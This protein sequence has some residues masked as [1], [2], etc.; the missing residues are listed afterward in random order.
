[1]KKRRIFLAINLPDQIK[2]KLLEFQREWADLPVRWTK[3][4]NLHI[5][6]V[7][8]GYIDD[9]EMLEICRLTKEIVQK[10][11][12]FEINL[13]RICLGPPHRPARMIWLE[14]EVNP[15]L[16]QLRDDLE[17]VLFDSTRSG[18]SK[19]ENRAFRP[20]ITLARIRLPEWR[21]LTTK[22]EI[23]KEVSLVFPVETVEV[24]ESHLSRGGAEYAVLESIKLGG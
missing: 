9:E 22:P 11:Q 20:H 23:D 18:F 14:G 6:L 3:E 16:A 7:F 21:H 2:K 15:A 13:K 1:M 10:H 4:S 24:M 17:E 12:S 5:T 8:I 19:R